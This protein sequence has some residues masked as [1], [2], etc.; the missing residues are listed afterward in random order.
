MASKL[1]AISILLA[2]LSALADGGPG[3]SHAQEEGAASMQAL[4]ILI[5]DNCWCNFLV[6]VTT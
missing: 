6:P 2:N 5:I 3:H 1:A 4:G